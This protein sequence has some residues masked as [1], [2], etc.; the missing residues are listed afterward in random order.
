MSTIELRPQRVFR[1]RYRCDACDHRWVWDMLCTG[2]DWCP[3]C[4]TA[5]EPY[6]SDAFIEWQHEFQFSDEELA[7]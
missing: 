6:R 3:E 5:T 7:A 4:E 1:N 2:R